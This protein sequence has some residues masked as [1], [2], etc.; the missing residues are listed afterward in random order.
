MKGRISHFPRECMF[1]TLDECIQLK[2]LCEM[3]NPVDFV[4]RMGYD[5]AVC[6]APVANKQAR[7]YNPDQR[8]LFLEESDECDLLAFFKNKEEIQRYA[9][10]SKWCYN[11][12]TQNYFRGSMPSSLYSILFTHS[13]K[14]ICI[15][16]AI[17]WMLTTFSLRY[18]GHDHDAACLCFILC[19]RYYGT[20]AFTNHKKRG[21]VSLS[22][23]SISKS[24]FKTKTHPWNGI[25]C[26]TDFFNCMI[27]YV[28]QKGQQYLGVV[29]SVGR[30]K[31]DK[32]FLFR[33]FRDFFDWV[34]EN[35]TREV[36]NS[37]HAYQ[38]R[39]KDTFA[40]L[41][42]WH[43]LVKELT[44]NVEDPREWYVIAC[45]K[46]PLPIASASPNKRL[47]V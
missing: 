30:D 44:S 9:Y 16:S 19:S 6:M 24:P 45:E 1:R 27:E 41:F 17:C 42:L 47:K 23:N 31:D 3:E 7:L 14:K 37:V 8:R 11:C 13:Q 10:A 5:F 25:S 22:L 40:K 21:T 33:D 46:R 29:C 4:L 20:D 15:N 28:A 39:L 2:T 34:E 38:D 43:M 18:K 36:L 32:R 26:S 12:I 35:K